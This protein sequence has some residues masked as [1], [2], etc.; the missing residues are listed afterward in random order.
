MLERFKQDGFWLAV[1]VF[2]I[3]ELGKIVLNVIP[4]ISFLCA[5]FRCSCGDYSFKG[6]KSLHFLFFAC[7]TSS[8]SQF[9]RAV[10]SLTHMA[11]SGT[12]RFSTDQT[13]TTGAKF[14]PQ[15]CLS[16]KTIEIL[17]RAWRDQTQMLLS[18]SS[19]LCIK[20]FQSNQLKHNNC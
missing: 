8:E 15:S 2:F 3:H 7:Q 5:V 9:G 20:P 12:F 6:K 18:S 16:D 17:W 1:N 13:C 14:S 10:L 4:T 19:P 11:T